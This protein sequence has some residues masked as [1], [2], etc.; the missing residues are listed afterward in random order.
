MANK[1]KSHK[2]KLE[3]VLRIKE[4]LENSIRKDENLIRKNNSRPKSEEDQINAKDTKRLYE[5]RLEQLIAIKLAIAG[6]NNDGG[7]NTNIF[8]LSNLN[9]RRVFLESLNT[10]EGERM[11]ITSDGKQIEFKA[12]F[13]YK[14]VSKEL[15]EINSQIRDIESKLSDFNHDTETEIKL[16]TELNLL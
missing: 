12:K 6:A 10:F 7:N 11:T 13:T 4:D 8:A 16:Y 15:E 1:N 5:L 2:L 9:R 14:E 3:Q